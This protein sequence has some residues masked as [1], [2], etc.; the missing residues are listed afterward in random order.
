MNNKK[1]SFVSIGIPS[2]FLI[3]SVLCLVILCLLTLGTSRSDLRLSELALDQ[4]SAYYEA[5]GEATELYNQA[6]K[7]AAEMY[8]QAGNLNRTASTAPSA[9]EAYAQDKHAAAYHAALKEFA[10]NSP[11]FTWDE[12]TEELSLEIPFS[13]SQALH[14]TLNAPFPHVDGG[15]Y[16]QIASWKTVATG[17]WE[18]D[19]RQPVFKSGRPDD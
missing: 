8:E 11:G 14:V 3:F 10:G 16:L 17:T 19:T 15:P 4:T 12:D 7:S 6:E 1:H 13:E 9:S 5:C 18:A 2:L